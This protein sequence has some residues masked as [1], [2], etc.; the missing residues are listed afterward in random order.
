MRVYFDTEFTGLKKD[1]TLVSIGLVSYDH[2]AFYAELTDYD[3]SYNDKW[4][5]DNVE[6]NLLYNTPKWR[7]DLGLLPTPED[8][9]FVHGTKEEVRKRL[10]EYFSEFNTVELVSDVCHYDMVLLIDLF[11]TAFDLPKN[12][13]PVCYDINQD[14][15]RFFDISQQEAFDMNREEIW[16]K[17][18][19][20][21]LWGTL[22]EVL[23]FFKETDLKHNSL[24][25]AYVIRILDM[26]M[27]D[28]SIFQVLSTLKGKL[29]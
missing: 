1:T 25:D 19:K 18:M 16:K 9:Y 3:K 20:E 4:F 27:H 2:K 23:K 14:I 29:I 22:K 12:V 11:G 6:K 21:N 28:K 15:A 24:Y 17:L 5:K 26:L 8:K 10:E 13:A 7:G